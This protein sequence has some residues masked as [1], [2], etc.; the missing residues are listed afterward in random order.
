MEMWVVN[1]V[2]TN[3][4]GVIK[5]GV[6]VRNSRARLRVKDFTRPL[7]FV[8]LIRTGATLQKSLYGGAILEQLMRTCNV[9]CFT[10]HCSGIRIELKS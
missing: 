10:R 2:D 7:M 4:R 1:L 9:S 8:E 3:V 5:S 6:G